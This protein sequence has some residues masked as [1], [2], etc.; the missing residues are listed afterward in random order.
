MVSPLTIQRSS[1]LL[2][3]SEQRSPAR[4]V[5]GAPQDSVAVV[6]WPD[7]VQMH[8]A[9]RR[10][11]TAANEPPIEPRRGGAR[12]VVACMAASLWGSRALQR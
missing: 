8:K 1:T 11:K 5:A 7:A 2:E 3:S 9:A 10:A 4:H 6:A 12:V